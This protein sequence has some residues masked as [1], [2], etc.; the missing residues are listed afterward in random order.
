MSEEQEQPI[1]EEP[2]APVELQTCS[3]CGV[4]Q[5]EDLV[6]KL[7]CQ[8]CGDNLIKAYKWL[9]SP[10]LPE[11]EIQ[12]LKQAMYDMTDVQNLSFDS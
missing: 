11:V 4:N 2:L 8:K 5:P 1:L 3:L 10:L 6:H 9:Q 12:E 7:Y